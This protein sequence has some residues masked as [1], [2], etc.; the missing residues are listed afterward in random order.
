VIPL[1]LADSAEAPPGY[2]LVE[3]AEIPLRRGKIALPESYRGKTRSV[4]AVIV[5]VSTPV[6]DFF[7]GDRVL[8]AHA[9]G[10]EV[11]FGERGERSLWKVSPR[12]VIALLY[13]EGEASSPG[14]APQTHLDQVAH[15]G[16]GDEIVWEEGDTEG[17]L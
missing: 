1:A 13:E 3:R 4:E 14:L 6:G 9:S 5:S 10:D 16:A 17:L 2:L 15:F 7:V 8:L 11:K 12:S